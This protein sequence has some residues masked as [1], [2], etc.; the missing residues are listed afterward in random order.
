MLTQSNLKSSTVWQP[1]VIEGEF[2]LLVV[3]NT[4]L[5][6]DFEYSLKISVTD[7]SYVANTCLFESNILRYQALSYLKLFEHSKEED[8]QKNMEE[9]FGYLTTAIACLYN[10]KTIYEAKEF[11]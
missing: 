9:D 2:I 10:A 7:V 1:M 4:Y 8:D 3:A 11:M 6:N 5:S